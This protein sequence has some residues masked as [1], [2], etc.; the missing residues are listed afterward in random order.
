MFVA[1]KFDAYQNVYETYVFGTL[2]CFLLIVAIL[3]A[4]RP[5]QPITLAALS[6]GAIEALYWLDSYPLD[7]KVTLL[8]IQ[9]LVTS[10][11]LVAL[12]GSLAAYL[13]RLNARLISSVEERAGKTET[14]YSR[15]N[16]AMGTAQNDS[17]LAGEKLSEGA[18]RSM[19]AIVSLREKTLAISRGMDELAAAL[20][21]SKSANELAVTRQDEVKSTLVSYSEEVARASAAI[22]EMA[23]SVGG[24]G[25][26]ANRKMEAVHKL[27]E[28]SRSGER[29]LSSMSASIEQILDSAK[30]MAEMNVFIG[31][32]A[33]RTNLLGMNASIEAAHAGNI[34]K[35]FAVVAGQI[36]ALSVEASTSSRTISETLKGTQAAV[37]AAAEKNKEAIDFFR[38]ISAEIQGVSSLLEELLENL[39]EI[40]A[41]SDDV[42]KAVSSVAE[43]TTATEKAVK[44]SVSSIADSS[45]GIASV[46][47]IAEVVHGD[48]SRMVKGFDE[49]RETVADV[50]RLGGENLKTIQGLKVG[51][52]SLTRDSRADSRDL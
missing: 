16:E 29:L 19:A 49:V 32:V 47:A 5:S 11:V 17:R 8:A 41:G 6:L 25:S 35:G 44:D 13:V 46:A 48:S 22:E 31:D 24:L 50:E 26:Q 39:R 33:D 12:G 23:A 51:L 2:G 45:A 30:R 20:G 14:A 38:R 3:V 1:I 27:D 37:E 40:S 18:T 9:N 42:L 7:G 21:K 28:L 43:L 36:R 34:G 15:L 4:D 52:D 10:S